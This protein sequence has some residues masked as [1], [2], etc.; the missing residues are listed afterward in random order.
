MCVIFNLNMDKFLFF[1]RKNFLGIYGENFNEL[2]LR[3]KIRND[4]LGSGISKTRMVRY[5]LISLSSGR[6]NK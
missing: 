1:L 5:N 2:L 6:E 4:H 3:M